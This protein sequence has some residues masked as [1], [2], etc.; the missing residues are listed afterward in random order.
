M[1]NSDNGTALTQEIIRSIFS[2][3]NWPSYDSA[4][5][6]PVELQVNDL[7]LC[8]GEFTALAKDQSGNTITVD[9]ELQIDDNLLMLTIPDPMLALD[10]GATVT[11]PLTAESDHA[12]FNV[13]YNL[14]V[15]FTED[16]SELTY[17][18]LTANRVSVENTEQMDVSGHTPS[19]FSR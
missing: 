13:E 14:E 12:F 2:T 18:N 7:A 17:Y 6:T 4:V 15:K 11:L 1:T 16:H 9:I 10:D 19:G 5:K 8:A 3:Y